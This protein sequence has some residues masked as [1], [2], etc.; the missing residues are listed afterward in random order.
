M[1]SGEKSNPRSPRNERDPS[2]GHRLDERRFAEI[3]FATVLGEEAVAVPGG[4]RRHRH[5]RLI[6]ADAAQIDPRCPMDP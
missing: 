6:E 3:E 4:A 5:D 1:P 2:L